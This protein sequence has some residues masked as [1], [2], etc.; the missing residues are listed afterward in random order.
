MQLLQKPSKKNAGKGEQATLS[1]EFEVGERIT[2]DFKSHGKHY[3]G[4]IARVNRD[5]TFNIHFDDGDKEDNVEAARIKKEAV[6][7][8]VGAKIL[9]DTYEDG[10]FFPGEVTA[11]LEDG[12]YK[13]TMTEGGLVGVEV[14]DGC[15]I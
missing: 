12:Y 2:G 5:G 13:V 4:K 11:V 7:F 14:K 15:F 3:P 9:A 1:A 6:Q 8:A 10:N